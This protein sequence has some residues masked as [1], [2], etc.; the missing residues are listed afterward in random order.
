MDLEKD[1]LVRVG[2][3]AKRK[4]HSGPEGLRLLVLGGAPGEPYKIKP[5][6]ELANA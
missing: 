2:P 4:V 3:A 5:F 6:S 1:V